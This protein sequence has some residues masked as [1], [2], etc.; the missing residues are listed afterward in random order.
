MRVC[1]QCVLVASN[2]VQID[3]GCWCSRTRNSFFLAFHRC[4]WV[5]LKSGS[6]IWFNS[7]KHCTSIWQELM[8]S[9]GAL[10]SYLP[11]T[12]FLLWSRTGWSWCRLVRAGRGGEGGERW[13][14]AW[15][16]ARAGGVVERGRDTDSTRGGTW[17]K[18]ATTKAKGK[19]ECGFREKDEENN[20]EDT[21]I[22][23]IYHCR[24]SS[25]GCA[26]LWLLGHKRA[27]KSK[28]W[29]HENSYCFIYLFHK[30]ARRACRTAHITVN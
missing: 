16:A 15:A 2:N 13:L 18:G 29:V 4:S 30:L 26:R 21:I 7:L 23:D 11:V 3:S 25:H 5:I 20:K 24:L 6:V 12:V 1:L 10:T 17:L 14:P 28:N 8:Q 27:W 9:P 19:P 22:A